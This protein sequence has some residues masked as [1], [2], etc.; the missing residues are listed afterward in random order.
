[1]HKFVDWFPFE[2]TERQAEATEPLVKTLSESVLK[3]MPSMDLGPNCKEQT[4]FNIIRQ[5]C[6]PTSK[7]ENLKLLGTLMETTDNIAPKVSSNINLDDI[8]VGDT[9]R[10][11]VNMRVLPQVLENAE[12]QGL[13]TF[14]VSGFLTKNVNLN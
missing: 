11:A 5:L 2:G 13:Q 12:A 7:P 14:D 3:G 6:S 10:I 8:R 4:F 1:L 9:E